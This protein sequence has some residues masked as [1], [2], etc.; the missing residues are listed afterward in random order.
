MH[1]VFCMEN[2]WYNGYRQP[3]Y[4]RSGD[5]VFYSIANAPPLSNSVCVSLYNVL[6]LSLDLAYSSLTVELAKLILPWQAAW[7]V[8]FIYMLSVVRP[9][10]RKPC[11]PWDLN[12]PAKRIGALAG[13]LSAACQKQER[14]QAVLSFFL[15]SLTVSF[16]YCFSLYILG[17]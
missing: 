15:A 16:S 13:L 2:D 5:S 14:R 9:S 7:S 8:S 3:K 4:W 10:S 1:A 11:F 17:C 6:H 12:M